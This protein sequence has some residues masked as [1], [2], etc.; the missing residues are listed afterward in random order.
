MNFDF[1]STI[2]THR[3]K[4]NV[5]FLFPAFFRRIG[6]AMV[7]CAIITILVINNLLEQALERE[8]LINSLLYKSILIGLTFISF[9]KDRYE[10]ER[11]ASLRFRSYS[12]AFGLFIYIFVTYPFLYAI[13]DLIHGTKPDYGAV[14]YNNAFF[15]I[16]FMFVSQLI[17]FYKLKAEL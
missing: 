14:F 8:D 2:L 4:K 17:Y 16:V 5:L 9:S 10:D 12:F 13:S 1:L 7:F 11:I 6:V 15:S 3:T